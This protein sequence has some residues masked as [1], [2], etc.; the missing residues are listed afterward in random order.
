MHNLVGI[1]RTEDELDKALEELTVLQE[2]ARRVTV[3]GHRQY[4]PGWHLA[5]D[6][7]RCSRCSE[8][9]TRRPG[10]GER[11]GARKPANDYPGTDPELAKVNVVVRERDGAL[12][13][14]HEP[15]PVMPDYLNELLE[16]G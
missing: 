16:D 13:L 1:I 3:E 14:A 5:V 11:A 9:I 15:L 7:R 2:R 4:N 10:S 8:C 6:L 12:S